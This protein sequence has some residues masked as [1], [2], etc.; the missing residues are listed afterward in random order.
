VLWR[1]AQLLKRNAQLARINRPVLGAHLFALATL[2]LIAFAVALSHWKQTAGWMTEMLTDVLR[3]PAS[4]AWLHP[5]LNHVALA[6]PDLGY[7]LPGLVL[8]A[9]LGGVAAYLAR[10]PR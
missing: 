8:I 5:D 7:L 2:M 4:P 9:V 6:H 1:R 10:E 3:L